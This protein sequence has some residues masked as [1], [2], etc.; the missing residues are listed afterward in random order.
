MKNIDWQT[1]SGAI[2]ENRPCPLEVTSIGIEIEGRRPNLQGQY[3]IWELVRN[4]AAAK[5]IFMK[6]GPLF[7]NR[8]NDSRQLFRIAN[9]AA[10]KFASAMICLSKCL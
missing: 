6:N 7:R 4:E 8:E 9:T 1:I 2:R 5:D 3:E 10:D